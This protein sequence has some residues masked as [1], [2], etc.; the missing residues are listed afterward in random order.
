MTQFV[1]VLNQGIQIQIKLNF[2]TCPVSHKVHNPH[3]ETCGSSWNGKM[4]TDFF[5]LLDST[6]LCADDPDRIRSFLK[7]LEDQFDA[8]KFT[9]AEWRFIHE[10]IISKAIP[11]LIDHIT[12]KQKDNLVKDWLELFRKHVPFQSTI[13][14]G[15]QWFKYHN[16]ATTAFHLGVA[17]NLRVS[18][19]ELIQMMYSQ[20]KKINLDEAETKKFNDFVKIGLCGVL[21]SSSRSSPSLVQ[22]VNSTLGHLCKFS[23]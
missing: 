14:I 4:S 10:K 11:A 2:E 6:S 19:L 16:L 22:I 8:V 12:N 5:T 1:I 23:N 17:N 20:R 7:T 13:L 9:D 21:T 15:D 3:L 18:G